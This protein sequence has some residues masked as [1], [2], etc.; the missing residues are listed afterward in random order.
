MSPDTEKRKLYPPIPSLFDS[1]EHCEAVTGIPKSV[2]SAAKKNGSLAVSSNGRVDLKLLLF[3]IFNR[4]EDGKEAGEDWGTLG[5]K[6]IAKIAEE[7]YKEKVGSVISRDAVS[8]CAVEIMALFVGHFRRQTNQLPPDL[9]GRDEIEIK[10][11]LEREAKDVEDKIRKT[12]ENLI[13]AKLA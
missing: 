2:I 1:M 13:A 4:Q 6:W 7:K 9:K 5:K 8:G 12:L 11:R 3:D 10:E